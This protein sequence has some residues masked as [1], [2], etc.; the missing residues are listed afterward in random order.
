MLLVAF[1]TSANAM[2]MSVTGI[3]HATTVTTVFN[4]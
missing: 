3:A 4:K 1:K 2:Q